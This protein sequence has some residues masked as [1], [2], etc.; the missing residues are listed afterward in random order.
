M[1]R[2]EPLL[3]D[4]IDRIVSGGLKPADL[5]RAVERVEESDDGWRR[6]ALAFIEEQALTEILR[7]KAVERPREREIL[8]FRPK[9]SFVRRLVYAASL[10][11]MA[12]GL[13]WLG[14]EVTDNTGMKLADFSPS[15]TVGDS[16]LPGPEEGV[17][18]AESRVLNLDQDGFQSPHPASPPSSR[19][20]GE[21]R[22]AQ[23]FHESGAVSGEGLPNLPEPD[24]SGLSLEEWLQDQPPAISQYDQAVLEREGYRVEQHREVLLG[25]LDDG[26]LAAVPVDQVAVEY[27]GHLPL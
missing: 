20:Q 14:H 4:T 6:L 27:V 1:N 15:R 2:P 7:E 9:S 19:F 23:A 24:R 22:L 26:R 17:R 10:A 3:G 16:L 13:G 25:T 21:S 5:R 11:A 12:F 8:P 18:A